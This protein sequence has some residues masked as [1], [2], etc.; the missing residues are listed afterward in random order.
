[1]KDRLITA[2]IILLLLAF[3]GL[4]IYL[5]ISTT[6]DWFLSQQLREEGLAT[7]VTVLSLSQHNPTR[8]ASYCEVDFAYT[9]NDNNYN[10]TTKVSPDFCSIFSEGSQVDAH[11]LA[12]K[13]ETADLI[14]GGYIENQFFIMLFCDGAAVLLAIAAAIA[15][16][17][18]QRSR[19]QT[20][21]LLQQ[22]P[23]F[24]L[25][26]KPPR[27]SQLMEVGCMFPFGLLVTVIMGGAISI[28]FL[29]WREM[30]SG[31]PIVLILSASPFFA[32]GLLIIYLALKDF[33]HSFTFT[34]DQIYLHHILFKN[35]TYPASH[36]QN[37]KIEARSMRDHRKTYVLVLHM[38]DG[39][40]I[41]MQHSNFA[42]NHSHPP[43]SLRQLQIHL[44]QLYSLS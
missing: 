29:N 18:N 9:L 33:I 36:L 19:Q 15:Y 3:V 43:E 39:T 17:L 23:G 14:W 24:P 26:I 40:T 22:Q 13:P 10:K 12:G 25:T 35:K 1:M 2:A 44:K 41:D 8:G 5:H 4:V 31:L 32:F 34:A 30:E 6:R 21:I 37:I 7:A 38:K 20:S 42:D 11:Y 28:A 16:W 27:G